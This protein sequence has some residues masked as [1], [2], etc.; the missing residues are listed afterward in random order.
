MTVFPEAKARGRYVISSIQ[1]YSHDGAVD[2]EDTE[3]FGT[4]L[5]ENINVSISKVTLVNNPVMDYEMLAK[6]C[7][8]CQKR[9]RTL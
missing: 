3:N 2:L 6:K 9:Q 5:E 1:A 7:I 4:V 8:L